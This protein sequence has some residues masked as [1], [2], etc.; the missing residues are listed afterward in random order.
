MAKGTEKSAESKPPQDPKDCK[1]S[2]GTEVTIEF[3]KD[4]DKGIGFTIAGGTDT[5]MV[6]VS[7]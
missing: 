6:S 2:V 4:K 7:C 1:I 5:P 3:Q